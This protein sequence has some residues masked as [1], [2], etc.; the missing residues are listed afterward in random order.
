[1]ALYNGEVEH[2][3]NAPMQER[4]IAINYAIEYAVNYI[5]KSTGKNQ[6]QANYEARAVSVKNAV[7]YQQGNAENCSD[8]E[9]SQ[10]Y[11]SILTSKFIAEGHA[12]I[13]GKFKKKP[14]AGN[15][16]SLAYKHM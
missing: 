11:F 10:K 12:I 5:S 7:S 8:A 3:N 13:L 15:F 2:V 14:I 9:K 1:M 6:A 4:R 16:N